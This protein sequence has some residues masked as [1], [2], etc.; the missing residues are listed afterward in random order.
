[1]DNHVYDCINHTQMNQ[2]PRYFN[3]DK[4][5]IQPLS[6]SGAP[7]FSS[8]YSVNTAVQYADTYAKNYNPAYSNFNSSG[9]DCANFVSQCLLAGKL[10]ATGTWYTYSS[11]WKSTT[12]LKNYLVN[13]HLGV[14]V[15]NPSSNNIFKGNPVFYQSGS[16]WA[17]SAICV[18]TN[19]SGTPIINAH[20]GDQYHANWTLGGSA[21]W[22][23][24]STVKMTHYGDVD[25]NAAVD[26]T[27]ARLILQQASGKNVIASQYLSMAD[28]THDGV[29]DTSD[30]QYVLSA[31]VS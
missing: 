4:A 8:V 11:A 15:N 3:F 5:N 20:N 26:T 13:N 1:M 25:G 23:G 29:I 31:A 21:Y 2:V 14:L 7:P 22:S 18:G 10:P 19:A 24:Y 16:V 6:I 27:D 30:A 9:G 28:V 12:N 17:H